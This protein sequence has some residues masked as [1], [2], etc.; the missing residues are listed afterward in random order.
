MCHSP[1]TLDYVYSESIIWLL[2]F[3]SL[4]DELTGALLTSD[5]QACLTSLFS[6][7]N[8][9]WSAVALF[10]YVGEQFFDR[11]IFEND[12]FFFLIGY[13]FSLRDICQ[14]FGQ[15]EKNNFKIYRIC[16][17]QKLP[18]QLL[19]NHCNNQNLWFDS[20]AN[21]RL[22]I[23]CQIIISSSNAQWKWKRKK[24][25]G[26]LKRLFRL[27]LQITATFHS[28]TF[29]DCVPISPSF[30][31]CQLTSP[32]E[33]LSLIWRKVCSYWETCQNGVNFKIQ[34]LGEFVATRYSLSVGKDSLHRGWP[35]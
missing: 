3:E 8:V 12:W 10:V 26:S 13:L 27:P 32:S 18:N 35:C 17:S 19:N 22:M 16:F 34:R 7:C 24:L 2:F 11:F 6:H 1:E 15:R 14:I 21:M 30:P 20:S 31:L 28:Q 29:Q 23:C 4:G 5:G 33:G 25:T 9:L